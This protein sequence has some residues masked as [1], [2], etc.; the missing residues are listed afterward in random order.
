M[1]ARL[2]SDELIRAISVPNIGPSF[3]KF[4]AVPGAMVAV[5]VIKK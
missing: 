3:G 2:N 1:D 5:G 4:I